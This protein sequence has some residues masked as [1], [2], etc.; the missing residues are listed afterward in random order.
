MKP[1]LVWVQMDGPHK[2]TGGVPQDTPRTRR[3][4]AAAGSQ[5]ILSLPTFFIIVMAYIVMAFIVMAL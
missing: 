2:T 3:P 1:E 5:S 4:L